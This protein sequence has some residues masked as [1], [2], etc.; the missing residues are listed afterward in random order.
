MSLLLLLLLAL[1]PLLLLLLWQASSGCTSADPSRVN[2]S[3][4]DATAQRRPIPASLPT[5]DFPGY[6]LAHGQNYPILL[7]GSRGVPPNS[8]L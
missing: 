6:L 4:A 2:S 1:R 7:A 8:V 5:F 3:K